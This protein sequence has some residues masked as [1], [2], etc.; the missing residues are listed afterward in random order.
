[1]ARGKQNPSNTYCVEGN[2]GLYYS[3]S[4]ASKYP[5]DMTSSALVEYFDT[6]DPDEVNMDDQDREM[7]RLQQK[8]W[9]DKL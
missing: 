6:S 2:D 8:S 1:M 3:I 5:E 7:R 4:Y 9:W